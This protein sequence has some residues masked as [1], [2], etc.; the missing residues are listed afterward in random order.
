[1]GAARRCKCNGVVEGITPS[2][3]M[4]GEVVVAFVG[5]KSVIPEAFSGV[6]VTLETNLTH[7]LHLCRSAGF[8]TIMWGWSWDRC[9]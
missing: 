7:N 8:S 5:A 9:R 3:S 4:V 1:M 2:G 6:G